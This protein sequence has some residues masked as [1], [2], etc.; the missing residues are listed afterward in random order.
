MQPNDTIQLVD[1]PVAVKVTGDV[2][3]PG[4]A[5]L[6]TSEP[7]SQALTQ[8]GGPAQS[9]RID[10]LQL[11]RG[12][13]TQD[14]SLGSPQFAQAAQNGDQLVVSRAAHVDVLGSV[15]KP[16]DT[17]LRGSNTLV[18]AIYYAGGPVKYANLRAVQVIRAGKKQ[19]YDLGKVQKGGDG[20][21]PQLL[22]GDVVFVPQGSTFDWSSV[23][24]AL[25][26]FGLFGVH[27]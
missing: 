4:I 26:S 8:V 20:D 22:D 17:M 23:W 6:D 10:H 27:L 16:G 1:K 25:G 21:N 7:L 12:G 24:G 2:V 3:R 15:E 9:S 11:V 5:Y 19:Q 18:S 13:A 14:V